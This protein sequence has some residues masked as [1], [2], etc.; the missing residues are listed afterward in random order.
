MTFKNEG[1][2]RINS[3]NDLRTFIPSTLYLQ[4]E[5]GPVALPPGDYAEYFE[6]LSGKEVSAGTSVVLENDRI[7]PAEKGETPIGVISANPGI[8]G[9][10][11]TEWPEKHLRDEL[12]NAILEEYREEVMVP[13]KEKVTRERQKVQKKTL[14]EEVTRTE[15]VLKG[16]KYLQKEVTERTTR[17]A[18]EPVFDEVDLYDATGKT[19]IGKHQVPVMETYGEEID[20]L[21]D[22]GQPVYAGTGKFETKERPK[23]NPEY[24]ESTEYVPREKRPEWNC[25]GLLGKLP[26]RKGQPV[27]ESWIKMKD[28]SDEVELWL[29]K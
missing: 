14:E 16:G 28:I 20:V 11:Y 8:V 2:S 27:A 18:E 21:D 26:L 6:S 7:R 9:G 23:L 13:K 24:D 10:A 29:V 12:G 17:E 19:V 5:G 25:V 22:H 15:I 1:H 3:F 4:T